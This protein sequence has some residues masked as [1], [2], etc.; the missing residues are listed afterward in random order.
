[1]TDTQQRADGG[2]IPQPGDTFTALYMW[3]G[4]HPNGGEGVMSADMEVGKGVIRHVPL[5]AFSQA[6]AAAL[7]GIALQEADTFR[8]R[9]GASLALKLV[10]FRRVSDG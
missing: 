6:A 3:I 4:T 9:C 8:R 1:M 2:N 10:T 7:G 5:M